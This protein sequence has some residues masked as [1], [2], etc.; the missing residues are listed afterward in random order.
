[1]PSCR[2]RSRRLRSRVVASARRRLL[3]SVSATASRSAS[4]RRLTSIGTQPAWARAAI[5][6]RARAESLPRTMRAISAPPARTPIPTGSASSLPVTSVQGFPRA[7]Q[8]QPQGRVALRSA[9]HLLDVLR[10][11][12]ARPHISGEL[13]DPGHRHEAIAVDEP[14]DHRGE[15]ALQRQQRQR[16]DER[17]GGR[18]PPGTDV[19]D[20]ARRDDDNGEDQRRADQGQRPRR[21][22][23]EQPVDVVQVV[24]HDRDP[25]GHGHQDDHR[26][27]E[28]RVGQRQGRTQ[29]VDTPAQQE[30]PDRHPP[31]QHQ[32]PDLL[33]APAVAGGG[34]SP[35]RSGPPR[36]AKRRP[37]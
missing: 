35:R 2:S 24:T 29:R 13:L 6:L 33:A 1:M 7:G 3:A 5:C 37:P 26:D 20:P 4:R 30:Q 12:R 32:P 25:H 28:R 27:E 36:P 11:P 22:R 21:G 9:E 8:Q 31:G 23:P 15:V 10:C 16:G 17:G 18:S 19:D 34:T 14:A